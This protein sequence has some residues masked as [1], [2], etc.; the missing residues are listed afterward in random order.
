LGLLLRLL[1]LTG[2]RVEEDPLTLLRRL[3]DLRLSHF[4]LRRR[5][6]NVYPLGGQGCEVLHFLSV[7]VISPQALRPPERLV[8]LL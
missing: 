5:P 7:V 3:L 1:G 6:G 8:R 4:F 2:P